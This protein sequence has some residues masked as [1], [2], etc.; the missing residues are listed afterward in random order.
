MTSV[1]IIGLGY[2]GLPLAQL[3]LKKG[4]DVYGLE[5][6]QDKIQKINNHTPQIKI[7][8]PQALKAEVIII[9][10]PTPI[11][12]S[13]KPDLNYIKA[14]C[15]NIA[16]DLDK[17][18]RL[19]ILESTVNPFVSRKIVLPIFENRG[20]KVGTDFFLAH[21][22]ERIDPGNKKWDVSNIP[23]VVGAIS[24]EGLDKAVN[25]YKQIVDG[26][27]MPL[28]TIEEAE[29]VKI[30]E[31]SLRATNIAFANE[32]AIVMQNLNID[33]KQVIEGVKTKPFGLSVC[34]PGPGV[35]GHCIPIDP[36]YLI[37][38]SQKRGFFPSFLRKALEVNNFMP[39]YTISLLINALNKA[40]NCVKN[41]NIGILGIAYK[42][43]VSDIRE[44]PAMVIVNRLK[45][46]GANLKIYD[47]Y[48]TQLNNAPIKE[49]L[50][51]EAVL[52]LTDH[53]EFLEYDYSGIPVVIDA[54][55]ILDK[56]K[57]DGVYKGIGRN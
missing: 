41:T 44:S 24:P 28:E 56:S 48:A 42:K 11:D 52:L 13:K 55:N 4:M 2:V 12:D 50:D 21:C 54:K 19:I 18:G 26:S 15:V 10:V 6:N 16:N 32:M 23:R 34:K 7:N 9:A 20:F 29:M 30:Y 49:I 33:T 1:C 40:G 39:S 5:V 37:N 47:P 25:F 36:F 57:I 14:A 35:G 22:P 17:N 27:I 3:C 43:N 53:T 38:E 46:M 45:K 31:N 51:C 8:H